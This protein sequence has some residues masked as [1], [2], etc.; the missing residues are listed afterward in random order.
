M[1]RRAVIEEK[2]HA[3]AGQNAF[4]LRTIALDKTIGDEPSV[5]LLGERYRLARL[6]AELAGGQRMVIEHVPGVALESLDDIGRLR[7][8]RLLNGV[9]ARP[10]VSLAR[11]AGADAGCRELGRQIVEGLARGDSEDSIRFRALQAIER[12]AAGS[13]AHILLDNPRSLQ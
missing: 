6:R 11:C 8:L 7:A 5:A 2:L 12:R 3:C 9:D 4:R 1:L 13:P 10:G